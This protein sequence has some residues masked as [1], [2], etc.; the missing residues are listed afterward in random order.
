MKD[1]ENGRPEFT[2]PGH[3][4]SQISVQIATEYPNQVLS[5]TVER[6]DRMHF[7]TNLAKRIFGETVRGFTQEVNSTQP[8]PVHLNLLVTMGGN[9][10]Y[11]E[12]VYGSQYDAVVTLAKWNDEAFSR[13]LVRA[14]RS[15]VLTE[16]QLDNVAH[17]AVLR[18]HDRVDVTE[19][20][21]P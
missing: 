3:A 8:V 5:L 19:L 20:R 10:N 16:Q 1:V 11:L 18:A 2:T 13:L 12:Q 17:A 7:P 21:A 9:R 14:V 15:C 6:R 4:P